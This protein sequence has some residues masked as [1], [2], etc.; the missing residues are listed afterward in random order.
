MNKALA[1]AAM[2]QLT[3]AAPS[4]DFFQGAQTAIF[5]RDAEDFAD[6]SCPMPEMSEDIERYV[7]MIEPVKM[8]MGGNKKTKK[9]QEPEEANPMVAMLDK[10]TSYT[11]Q[12][13]IIMSVMNED[14]E[15]GD[16]CQ[17]LTATFEAK[18]IA[19]QLVKGAFNKKSEPKENFL[20]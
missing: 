10:L 15:G 16:F 18:S 13:G 6:Y 14:Y 20:Q 1:A 9:G 8:M 12:V 5:L 19:M 2:L 7:N 11:E 3:Q 17:G 4:G